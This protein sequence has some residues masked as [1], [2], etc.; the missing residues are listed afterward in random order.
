M[1]VI[2]AAPP[3]PQN[4]RPYS[5][6]LARVAGMIGM[7]VSTMTAS[8][9]LWLNAYFN[10]NLRAC[11]TY[12]NWLDLCPMGEARFINNLLSGQNSITV[13][14][15]SISASRAVG[16]AGVAAN[17]LD[18][19]MNVSSLLELAVTQ[20]HDASQSLIDPT[21]VIPGITYTASVFARSI[22][23]RLLKLGVFDGATSHSAF[24]NLTTGAAGTVTSGDTSSIT[25][26]S[27]G[28]YFC[29]LLFTASAT[30]GG[31]GAAVAFDIAPASDGSTTFYAG[32]TTKGLYLYGAQL[33]QTSLLSDK[34]NL[35]PWAQSG[36][37]EIDTPYLIWRNAPF[38]A[39]SPTKLGYSI[40]NNGIQ[41][42][43]NS[44]NNGYLMTPGG[45]TVNT[46]ATSAGNPIYIYYRWAPFSYFGSAFSGTA[47]YAVNDIIQFTTSA[48]VINYYTCLVATTAGQ[49]PTTTPASW[50]LNWIPD[51]L[52]QYVCYKGYA[53]WLRTD[54]QFDKANAQE[55]LS[56]QILENEF[57]TQEREMGVS[58]PLRVQTHLTS[59]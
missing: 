4:I 21:L 40:T 56:Q 23:G 46:S 41:L 55:G 30:A 15:W 50:S 3:Q 7:D 14:L 54:G 5:E 20:N 47:T 53:D 6:Y 39:N 48:G 57:D 9:L 38:S 2:P 26:V 19:R 42:I 31:V 11:W 45:V 27:G 58:A 18:G 59:R 33:T 8:E 44:W 1:P 52:F 49:S 51:I 24:F 22:G 25:A 34:A 32:D 35:L 10:N 13:P 12:A 28:Y 43:G 29:Q 36:E 17:P 16:T 37:P